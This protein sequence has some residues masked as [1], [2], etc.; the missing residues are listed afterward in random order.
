MLVRPASPIVV[1]PTTRPAAPPATAPALR[2]MTPAKAA[3]DAIPGLGKRMLDK[4]ADFFLG[5]EVDAYKHQLAGPA[6]RIANRLEPGQGLML[7]AQGSATLPAAALAAWL[8]GGLALPDLG[9]SARMAGLLVRRND[10]KLALTLTFTT[11]ESATYA[12][13]AGFNTGLTLGG[14]TLGF[15]LGHDRSVGAELGQAVVVSLRFDPAKPADA[16]CLEELLAF[17]LAGNPHGAQ[18]PLSAMQAFQRAFTHNRQ[19]LS[20]GGSAGANLNLTLGGTAGAAK[21]DGK[22]IASDSPWKVKAK[23][24]LTAAVDGQVYKTYLRDGSTSTMVGFE[25][26]VEGVV[27]VP[28]LASGKLV[29]RAASSFN[30]TYGPDGA[31]NDLSASLTESVAARAAIDLGKVDPGLK[32]AGK[33]MVT[34]ALNAEGL[35]KARALVK[36]GV[37]PFVA[38]CRLARDPKLVMEARA[39]S[40]TRSA[41]VGFDFDAAIAGHEVQLLGSLSAG[42]VDRTAS[43]NGDPGLREVLMLMAGQ[44]RPNGF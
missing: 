28:T 2:V 4:V 3:H 29:E 10:G 42:N 37:T 5:R 6:G 27:K 24:G 39:T 16:R 12:A 30:V 25:G 33:T 43:D 9:A 38:Y 26:D 22:G 18:P 23:L 19:S 1:P 11:G 13:G 44:Q 15:K 17:G 31:L 40:R 7:A 8:P 32:A 34:R 41:L 14:R 36:A 35:E 20:M 21:D